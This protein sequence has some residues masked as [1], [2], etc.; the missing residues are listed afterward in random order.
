MSLVN[1]FVNPAFLAYEGDFPLSESF[2]LHLFVEAPDGRTCSYT[3]YFVPQPSDKEPD[4]FEVIP[5]L[6]VQAGEKPVEFTETEGKVQRIYRALPHMM[7]EG[8]IPAERLGL[9]RLEAGTKLKV[10][11]LVRSYYREMTMTWGGAA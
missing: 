2:Q 7:L 10:N 4:G 11:V 3:V 9:E 6:A 1:T 5:R 8:I